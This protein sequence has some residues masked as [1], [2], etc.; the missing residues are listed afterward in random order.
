MRESIRKRIEAVR[1]G[2]V[3]E[4][5]STE[6][7][8]LFPDE[9]GTPVALNTVLSENKDCNEDLRFDKEDVLS[10]SGEQGIVNQIDLLGR[11]YA[12]Q[13]VAP[14][15]VV[16]TGDVVYTKSPLKENP[17]GII[18][19]N[20]GV[21][22]IVSTLYA[23]YHCSTP[24]TGQYLENYFCIDTYL[25]NYLK[26]LVKRGAKNDMKVNNEEVLLG[27]IPLPPL[28]EQERINEI[29]TQFDRMIELKQSKIDELNK[30]KQV[31]LLEMFPQKGQ[32]IPK[33]RFPGFSVPWEQR[34]LGELALFN[35]KDEL[36]QTFEYVDLESVVGTEMLSHR[37]EVKSSA[38]SRAQRLAHTGDLFYQT[39]RPYQKNNYLFEKPDNNYVFS[40]GYAQM[41][42]YVDGYFLLSLVQSER[43]VKVVLDN[44]T[45]TSYPAINANDLAEIEV[46]APSD[47]SE[48]QKI[49]TIFR[50]ID[51]LITLHQREL[52]E[53][54]KYKKA[55]MQLLLTGLV[56]VNA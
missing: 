25:N 28:Q 36:P 53:V 17:Y 1:R 16:E 54:G 15:H 41:R 43:F 27:R 49:G 20:R 51:N 33:R 12:G 56:R 38:P 7:A 29:I 30:L 47:E 50:S 23:V 11:S 37:T 10:V 55:L 48:A 46:A 39:V 19:Q 31:C 42:P 5:Y 32:T 4:K 52:A 18:K 26:P 44:C 13:S 3:P 21:P 14:Y 22:G 9:W 2:K 8:M 35:P 6:R 45:G 24:I 40:T 34:K